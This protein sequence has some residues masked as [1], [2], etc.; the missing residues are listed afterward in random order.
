MQL[1]DIEN[2]EEY[3]SVVEVSDIGVVT[4]AV[5]CGFQILSTNKDPKNAPRVS[6]L[7]KKTKSF[8]EL[9]EKYFK[10]ELPVD[11]K[12]FLTTLR[13]VKSSTVINY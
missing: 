13:N 1:K 2:K 6:F 5:V 3:S 7:F 4:S 8:E 11:A 9:V 12:T 10:G